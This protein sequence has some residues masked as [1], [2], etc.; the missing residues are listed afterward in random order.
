MDDLRQQRG[1]VLVTGGALALYDTSVDAFA[2]KWKLASLAISK[3]AQHKLV[4][5]LSQTLSAEGI[6]VGEVVVKGTVKGSAFDTGGGNLEAGAISE[7]FWELFS[8][9]E[10]GSVTYSG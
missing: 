3:A 1:A 8:K 2:T 6:Y 4:G 10:I 5:L 7:K 9:R